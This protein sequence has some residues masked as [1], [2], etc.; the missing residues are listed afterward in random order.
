MR[1]IYTYAFFI[2]LVIPTTIL[3]AQ[4][5]KKKGNTTTKPTVNKDSINN[6][7]AH[8]KDNYISS[9]YNDTVYYNGT[10][11]FLYLPETRAK[12]NKI[13]KAITFDG[14]LLAYVLNVNYI[15][16]K[17][18][19]QI[20]YPQTKQSTYGAQYE[21]PFEVAEQFTR[22]LIKGSFTKESVVEIAKVNRLVLKENVSFTVPKSQAEKNKQQVDY[23]DNLNKGKDEITAKKIEGKEENHNEFLQT[24][25]VIGFELVSIINLSKKKMKI[26]FLSKDSNAGELDEIEILPG[27]STSVMLK[28]NDLIYLYTEKNAKI[29]NYKYLKGTNKIQ[30][31]PD[32][33][34]IK[35]VAKK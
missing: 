30:I 4:D 34:G 25:K 35:A 22:Y 6:A 15:N 23:Y 11:V 16:G 7:Y 14:T 28:I 3:F 8:N 24:E 31:N 33:L 18:L 32:G 21:S 5:K 27:E 2:F 9:Q 1:R 26:K 10:G 13:F 19:Y 29:S 12:N 17:Y 20:N